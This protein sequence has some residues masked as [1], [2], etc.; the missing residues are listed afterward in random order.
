MQ[1]GERQSFSAISIP[2]LPDETRDAV[3][4]ALNAMSTLAQ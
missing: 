3:N 1:K 4:A 2:G